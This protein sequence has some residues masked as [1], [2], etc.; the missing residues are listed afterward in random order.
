MST[1][2][3]SAK[4]RGSITLMHVHN[5]AVCRYSEVPWRVRFT[6]DTVYGKQP[7]QRVRPWCM[8]YPTVGR[9]RLEMPV[10]NTSTQ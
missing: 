8:L 4:Q 9:L 3:E 2:H 7:W 5:L 10:Q 6:G 1:V